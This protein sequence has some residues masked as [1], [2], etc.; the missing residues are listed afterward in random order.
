MTR[1]MSRRTKTIVQAAVVFLHLTDIHFRRGA[2][3]SMEEK[4]FTGTP[5]VDRH[6]VSIRQPTFSVIMGQRLKQG[7]NIG[8]KRL[9]VPYFLQARQKDPTKDEPMSAKVR[10]SPYVPSVRKSPTD[11]QNRKSK[12][13]GK[14][15]TSP[16]VG[17]YSQD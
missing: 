9:D 8:N 14:K 17:E 6:S 10:F 13:E 12:W 7:M 16:P 3:T 15:G 4:Y 1:I 2:S 5:H 11:G